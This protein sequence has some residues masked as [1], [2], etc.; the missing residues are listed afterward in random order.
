MNIL[1]IYILVL[2]IVV[3]LCVGSFLNVVIYRL[4]NNMKLYFPPSH[5]PTCNYKLKWYDNI[6]LI[7]YILLHGKCRVCKEKISIRYPLVEFGNMALW[8]VCLLFFTDIIIKTN[9]NDYVMFI[10]SCL[11]CSTL[12]CV[13][14]CD[15]EHLVIPDEL[16]MILLILGLI[17]TFS[18][19]I[20]V[21]E[22]VIGFFIGGGFFWLVYIISYAIKKRE[23]MGFGDVKLMAVVGLFLGTYNTILIMILSSFI[24]SI[25]LSIL[26]KVKKEGKDKEYPFA[27]FIVPA[28][29][30]VLFVG[31]FIVNWYL[32]LFV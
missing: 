18:N 3:G 22:Q 2:T 31:G 1:D 19:F 21:K 25:I 8:F 20:S 32:S 30:I 13:F 23:C 17:S 11:F 14:F 5:C 12:I 9:T 27:V 16:Q 26:S 7:S 24:G 28:T 29:I 6:P 4:P 10:T 15:M